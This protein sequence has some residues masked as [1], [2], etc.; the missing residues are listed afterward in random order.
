MY[1]LV[2]F[3]L[4]WALVATGLFIREKVF[5]DR[6]SAIF[7]CPSVKFLNIMVRLLERN[8]IMPKFR[9]DIPG[10]ITR[11]FMSNGWIFN[12]PHDKEILE[13][14]GNP[15]AAFAI[16]VKDPFARAKR[17]RDWLSACGMKDVEIL[18][19]IDPGVDRDKLIAVRFNEGLGRFCIVYRMHFMDMSEQK[20]PDWH[21]DEEFLGQMP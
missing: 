1:I 11:A 12:C 17:D 3:L 16:M 14:M 20:P 2:G 15:K 4:I 5:V 13:R 6:G 10:K 21:Y 18:F 9:I 7:V 19:D 8:G